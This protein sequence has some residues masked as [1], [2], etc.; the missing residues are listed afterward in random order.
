MIQQI[1]E[2]LG[3]GVL[4]TIY[5]PILKRSKDPSLTKHKLALDRA[6]IVDLALYIYIW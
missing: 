3:F 6:V 5:I 2:L 4:P 1:N